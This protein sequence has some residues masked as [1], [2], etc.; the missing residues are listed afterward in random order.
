MRRFKGE[1]EHSSF[2][3]C[4]IYTDDGTSYKYN[5]KSHETDNSVECYLR[6]IGEAWLFVGRLHH[7]HLV[8]GTGW[9]GGGGG[10]THFAYPYALGQSF[11]KGVG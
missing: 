11:G 5:T 9:L 10:V 3:K 4:P 8:G 7:A 1:C 2:N 6:P